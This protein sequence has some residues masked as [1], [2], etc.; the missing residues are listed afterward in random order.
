VPGER[1][2]GDEAVVRE[3]IDFYR[4]GTPYYDRAASPSDDAFSHRVL[5]YCPAS[6]H[7]CLELASGSG[8]WT[9]SLLTRC[10]RITA[11]DAS[12]ERHALSR[13]RIADPRIEY[14]EADL[15]EF[16]GPIT[17]DL[18]FAGFWLSH[19]PLGRFRS[20]WAMVADAL[21]PDGC[22]VMVDDG[23]RDASGA[24]RF[25]NGPDGTGA[26]RK[27]PNGKVF[28]IVKVAYAPEELEVLLGDLGWTATVTL[29]TP[30]IYV[31]QARR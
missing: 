25:V 10:E 16:R 27:L 24:V 18:V 31:L 28:S 14:I 21:A 1:A 11:V 6:A 5:S 19:V 22:V 17:Y 2:A 26:E 3:Q 20:F 8:R 13:A 29:L 4:E 30:S 15:F 12:P 9:T 7:H 23:T